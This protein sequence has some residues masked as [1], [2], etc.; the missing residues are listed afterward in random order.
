VFI[1]ITQPRRIASAFN[2]PQPLTPIDDLIVG[3]PP[4]DGG[5]SVVSQAWLKLL[6]FSSV[7]VC[8]LDVPVFEP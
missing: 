6:G 2:T 5:H 7:N 8:N 4:P 3:Q 1:C